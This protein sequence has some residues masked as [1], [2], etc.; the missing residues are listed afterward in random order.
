MWHE[1]QKNFMSKFVSCSVLPRIPLAETVPCYQCP[2]EVCTR[3]NANLVH[4]DDVTKEL[5]MTREMT[6]GAVP[7]DFTFTYLCDG[8]LS[9]VT[10]EL[11]KG[12][13]SAEGQ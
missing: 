3:L 11:M 7:L 8:C 13:K 1:M 9:D 6:M 4:V 2:N 5:L 12:E 10:N